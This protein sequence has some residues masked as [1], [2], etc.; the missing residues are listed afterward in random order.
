M[1]EAVP[2]QISQICI[3]SRFWT[4]YFADEINVAD[5]YNAKWTF[6]IFPPETE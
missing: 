3:S 6:A 2:F 4:G 1:P 5:K